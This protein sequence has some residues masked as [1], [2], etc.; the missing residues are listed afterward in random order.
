MERLLDIREEIKLLVEIRD[1]RDEIKII[2]SVVRKQ[3]EA[4]EAMR[5]FPDPSSGAML[6]DSLPFDVVKANL[7]DFIRLDSQALAVQDRVS[8]PYIHNILY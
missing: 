6:G 2:L 3:Q 1:I 8:S 5:E 7:D 4:M